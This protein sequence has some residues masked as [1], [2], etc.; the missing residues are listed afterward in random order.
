MIFMAIFV[1]IN[2]VKEHLWTQRQMS[3]NSIAIQ[4]AMVALSQK[5]KKFALHV[6][7]ISLIFRQIQEVIFNIKFKILCR[8]F[9]KRI[10]M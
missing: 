1:P 6:V 10:R 4:V 3:V 8:M 2:A 5:T 7:Q 9:G